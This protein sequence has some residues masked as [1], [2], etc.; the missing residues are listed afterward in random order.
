MDRAKRK[1][2]PVKLCLVYPLQK[3]FRR[4]LEVPR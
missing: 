3:N 4:A 1:A 2:E